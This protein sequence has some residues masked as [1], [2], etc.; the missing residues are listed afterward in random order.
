MLDSKQMKARKKVQ[1]RELRET[2]RV[3][4]LNTDAFTQRHRLC[5]H[6]NHRTQ[7]YSHTHSGLYTNAF[8]H[9]PFE[10]RC[11]YTQTLVPAD[12]FTRSQRDSYTKSLPHTQILLHTTP[13]LHRCFYTQTP[14][15]TDTFIH[16]LLYTQSL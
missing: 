5:T 9:R 10:H 7:I 11:F 16:R 4:P 6:R 2:N 1:E 8:T 15:H 13:L 3:C 12:A 14:L